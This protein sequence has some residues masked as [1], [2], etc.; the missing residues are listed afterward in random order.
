MR[1]AA[2][3]LGLCALAA[4]TL[5]P[6]AHAQQVPVRPGGRAV[7]TRGKIKVDYAELR[8]GPGLAFLARGRAYRGDLV[9]V[10]AR[11][12][13]GDWLEITANGVRGF[14]PVRAVDLSEAVRGRAAS[15]GRDRRQQNYQYD[16]EG[17]R[18][19]LDGRTMG[20]G[21]GT[22]GREEAPLP[23]ALTADRLPL[24]VWVG[25]GAGR[26]SRDFQAG[27]EPDSPLRKLVV[28]PA[29]ITTEL[30]ADYTPH[31]HLALRLGF[32]DARLSDAII[33]ANA[34][35]GFSDEISINTNAQQLELDVIGRLPIGPGFVGAYGGLW[36]F[37]QAF[38]RTN[39]FALFLTTT[40]LGASA[41]LTAGATLGPIELTGRGGVALP[42]SV[43]QDPQ[44]SGDADSLGLY[45]GLEVAWQLHRQWA[46]VAAGWY[47]RVQTD[48]SGG[49]THADPVTGGDVV[50]DY[51]TAR[52]TDGFL[53]GSLGVRWQP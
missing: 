16:A 53:G 25:F 21:E 42:L 3:R 31:R 24:R 19:F 49:G 12:E 52:Q 18:V 48:F 40:F 6:V 14:V 15:G 38:Q 29:A 8:A 17:R 9:D 41:G 10:L 44:D 7:N 20:S 26:I 1:S 35:Y 4:L 32:R 34:A 28:S 37:R 50:R 13:T 22:V 27:I 47:T 33:P 46:L 23:Q 43:S 51:V 5:A 36:L 39:P 30:G 11:D 45:G 2:R